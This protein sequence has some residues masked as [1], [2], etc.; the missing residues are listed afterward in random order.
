MKAAIK[1][2]TRAA[3]ALQ[4]A[5]AFFISD[6]GQNILYSHYIKGRTNISHGEMD[7]IVMGCGLAPYVYLLAPSLLLL[8]VAGVLL[9]IQKRAIRNSFHIDPPIA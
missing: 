7:D 6:F 1:I 5:C 4:I 9:L 2:L 3:L 8:L